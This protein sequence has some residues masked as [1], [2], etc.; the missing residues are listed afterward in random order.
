MKHPLSALL[1]IPLLGG[2]ASTSA[3]DFGDR[4]DARL[5]RRDARFDH[6]WDRRY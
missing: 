6:R 1:G 2:A 5:D 4:A 3:Y